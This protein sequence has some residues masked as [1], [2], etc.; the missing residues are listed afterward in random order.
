MAQPSIEF[1]CACLANALLHFYRIE[2]PPVPIEEMLLTP[3]PDLASDLA[4]V[5]WAP[6]VGYMYR[7][8]LSQRGAV[9]VHP[10][11][12]P[13]EQRMA[14]ASGLFLGLRDSEGGKAIGLGQAIVSEDAQ[15]ESELFAR[16]LLMPAH[17]L[18][19]DWETLPPQALAEIFEV[20]LDVAEVR[21]DEL[22]H[23]N[24]KTE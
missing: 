20:P 5:R 7:R 14:M 6:W 21:L 13:I 24:H 17:L 10:K 9:Y 4:L 16:Y 1:L 3:P 19:P 22:R 8:G 11:L 23:E 12:E 15:V 2:R 18:P